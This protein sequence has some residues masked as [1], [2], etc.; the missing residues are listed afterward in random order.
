M[1]TPGNYLEPPTMELDGAEEDQTATVASLSFEEAEPECG[2]DIRFNMER[3]STVYHSPA[4]LAAK[5]DV[6]VYGKI[7][8]AKTGM[9]NLGD[10][11]LVYLEMDEISLPG[12]DVFRSFDA[13]GQG[14]LDS[15]SATVGSCMRLP[16]RS[17]WCMLGTFATAVIR[18]SYKH[19]QKRLF[20]RPHSS[21][22]RTSGISSQ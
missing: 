7:Y 5:G 8:G 18:R 22:R 6:P 12:G 21:Q 10:G 17:A 9:K 14:S 15:G 13:E 19:L 20:R 16:A 4:F 1:F 3:T 2:P 11:D